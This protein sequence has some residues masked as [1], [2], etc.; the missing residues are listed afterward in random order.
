MN[1]K[2]AFRH[3]GK[4]TGFGIAL[5]I[6]ISILYHI[7]SR[8]G[9]NFLSY[10]KILITVITIYVTCLIISGIIKLGIIKWNQRK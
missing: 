3:M 9:I 8:F 6:F 10:Q 4:K 1:I 5:L 7:L 2:D